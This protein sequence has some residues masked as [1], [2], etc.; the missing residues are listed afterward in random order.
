LD[1]YLLLAFSKEVED[2]KS[3]P[4]FLCMGGNGEKLETSE[5]KN[6]SFSGF[7]TTYKLKNGA[8]RY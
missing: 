8:K 5:P 2:K 3:Y 7:K 6:F 4:Q 1:K